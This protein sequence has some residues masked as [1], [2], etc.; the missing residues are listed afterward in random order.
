MTILDEDLLQKKRQFSKQK[1][2]QSKTFNRYS[3]II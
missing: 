3:S 2:D 1:I